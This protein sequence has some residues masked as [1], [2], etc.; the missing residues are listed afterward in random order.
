MNFSLVIKFFV[1]QLINYLRLTVY[2]DSYLGVWCYS[3][4]TNIRVCNRRIY[5]C[6]FA[7]IVATRVC[8]SLQKILILRTSP[9]EPTNFRLAAASYYSTVIHMPKNRNCF[10]KT[11][12]NVILNYKSRVKQK[13][14]TYLHT[15]AGIRLELLNL[16][17]NSRVSSE[18]QAGTKSCGG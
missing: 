7:L 5:H 13:S 14:N 9:A 2:Q 15:I 4:F 17:T 12:K 3:I 18:M 1:H 8:K 16:A 11:Q 10:N 6:R